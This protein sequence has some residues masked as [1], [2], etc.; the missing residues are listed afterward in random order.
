MSDFCVHRVIR[1]QAIEGHNCGSNIEWF[2]KLCSEL[3]VDAS[4]NKIRYDSV[5][6]KCV[7][8]EMK[9]LNTMVEE[10]LD[11]VHSFMRISYMIGP[12]HVNKRTVVICKS[13]DA[14]LKVLQ[15]CRYLDG[16]QECKNRHTVRDMTN[17]RFKRAEEVFN[18]T[19]FMTSRRDDL[20]V[21]QTQVAKKRQSGIIFEI[22]DTEVMTHQMMNVNI[23][24][25]ACWGLNIISKSIKDRICV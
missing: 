11:V 7:Q 15:D 18:G 16:L 25:F 5:E 9:S 8:D 1:D 21:I 24:K 10:S 4:W 23:G 3:G 6:S 14:V 22:Q 12:S 13:G 2:E 17:L 20:R 19:K